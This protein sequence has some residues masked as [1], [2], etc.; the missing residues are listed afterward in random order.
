MGLF[1]LDEA[2]VLFFL[3]LVACQKGI[4]FFD[5]LGRSVW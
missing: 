3:K 5:V 2:I 1:T 4:D